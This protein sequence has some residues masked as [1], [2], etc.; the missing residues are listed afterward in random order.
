AWEAGPRT[1][2]G[3]A[4]HGFPNMFMIT[5]PGSPSVLA[6]VIACIEQHVEWITDCMDA[7]RSRG[8]IEIEA[9]LDDQDKWVDH[10]NAVASQTLFMHAKSWYLGDNIEGK[11][12]VFMPYP[13]GLNVYRET[14][15]AV[16]KAGYT[17]FSLA[18]SP[19]ATHSSRDS[20]PK[21]QLP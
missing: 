17:G 1:Y 12:R 16:A 9:R 6:N 10:V 5:G 18:K 11:P 4:T 13:G 21:G 19:A 8:V 14:C 7:L 3:V 15:A 2:L 20:A